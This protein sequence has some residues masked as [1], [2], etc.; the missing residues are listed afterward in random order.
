MLPK[1]SVN[2]GAF[3]PTTYLYKKEDWS[4]GERKPG[5]LEIRL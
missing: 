1:Y 4:R 3:L 2:W 5:E